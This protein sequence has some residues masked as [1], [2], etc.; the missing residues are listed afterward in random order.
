MTTNAKDI[1]AR[2]HAGKRPTWA[3]IRGWKSSTH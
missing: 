1:L 2:N 3:P